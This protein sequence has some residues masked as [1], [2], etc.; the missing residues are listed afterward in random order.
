[1]D[2]KLKKFISKL[3]VEQ[4]VELYNSSDDHG[5][6]GKWNSLFTMNV[7]TMVPLDLMVVIFFLKGISIHNVTMHDPTIS[8]LCAHDQ[9]GF[10]HWL[11]MINFV[12]IYVLYINILIYVVILNGSIFHDVYESQDTFFCIMDSW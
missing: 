6:D 1:M 5:L 7:L 11:L 10:K 9:C 12:N 3:C 4:I 2:N 8:F